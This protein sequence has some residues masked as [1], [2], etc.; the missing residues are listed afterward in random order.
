MDRAEAKM[1][2]EAYRPEDAGDPIFT[3]ALRL[4]ETDPDLAAW[5]EHVQS[6]DSIL[7]AKI[8]E[9]PVPADVRARI[10]SGY[11]GDEKIIPATHLFRALSV[12]AS[13]AALILFGL[14]LWHV[15]AP[16]PTGMDA[17]ARQAVAFSGKMPALQFVCFNPTAVADWVNRQ[18]ASR[19]VGLTLPPQAE[20]MSMK[21][22]GS[23]IVQ[24]D[25]HPVVMIALQNGKQMAMLYV[26]KDAVAPGMKD[27]ATETMREA[28]W[29]VRATKSHG[30]L[31]LLA[32]EGGSEPNFPM[33]F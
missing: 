26:M 23:S 5:F 12:P 9:A 3:K 32:A 31:Q 1:L 21:L 18:P 10:L 16:A 13:L 29:I 15:V 6:I 11:R 27:G 8:R 17:L 25:G 7:A 4:V 24:W 19:S 33:P 22:I 28:N 30:E 14:F 2:L 20:A